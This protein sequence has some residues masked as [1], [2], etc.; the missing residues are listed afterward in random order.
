MMV[1]EMLMMI[2]MTRIAIVVPLIELKMQTK[3][4]NSKK[5][6]VQNP[7]AE[8]KCIFWIRFE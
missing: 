1:D 5:F 4:E 3:T 8:N 7:E 2:K 6:N